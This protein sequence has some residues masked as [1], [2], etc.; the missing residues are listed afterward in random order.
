[1]QIAADSAAMAGEQ[2]IN[3]GNAD[4]A[5][6]AAKNDAALNGYTDGVSRITVTVNNPPVN[7]PHS[8]DSNAVEVI[9][10]RVEPTMLLKFVGISTITISARAAAIEG[11][12]PYCIIALNP[13]ATNAISLFGAALLQTCA[14]VDDS[15]A[16]R[17][18][19]IFGVAFWH[20][21]SIVLLA[22]MISIFSHSCHRNR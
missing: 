21:S 14:I 15:N 6:T 11:N 19:G 17:A 9:V 1:M 20:A 22:I 13:T 12:A 3:A 16:T 4:D 7:G 2:E 18:F 5:V 10:S 8:G